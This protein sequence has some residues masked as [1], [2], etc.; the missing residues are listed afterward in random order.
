M[1]GAKPVHEL[2]KVIQTV[3]TEERGRTGRIGDVLKPMVL[4]GLEDGLKREAG[5]TAVAREDVGLVGEAE[6]AEQR[7]SVRRVKMVLKPRTCWHDAVVCL[8]GATCHPLECVL[9]L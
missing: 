4:R 1:G 8:R 2:G 3:E 5:T 7:E 6:G 9:H